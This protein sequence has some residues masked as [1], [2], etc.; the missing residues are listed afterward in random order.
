MTQEFLH[1]SEILLVSVPERIASVGQQVEVQFWRH[2]RI[3]VNQGKTQVW[4][5]SGEF[6][7]TSAQSGLMGCG[8]CP[9]MLADRVQVP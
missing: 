3:E 8:P 1:P 5:R 6:A 2:S 7:I 4:N 9:S